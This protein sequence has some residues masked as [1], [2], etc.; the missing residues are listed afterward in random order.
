MKKITFLL[1]SLSLGLSVSAQVASY[2]EGDFSVGKDDV[3]T[4]TG[5][6]SKLYF[7]GI[8]AASSLDDVWLAKYQQSPDYT[9]L[10]INLGD[11]MIGDDRLLIGATS[12]VD[13]LFYS[14]IS[15]YNNG[16]VGINME[17]PEYNLHV[18]GSMKANSISSIDINCSG[19]ILAENLIAN[20]QIYTPN[21]IIATRIITDTLSAGIKL[22]GGSLDI[23]GTIKA[24]KLDLNGTIK[25]KEIV[26]TNTVWADFVFDKD[27][28]LPSLY[29]VE[30]HIQQHQTLPGI[31]SEEE[32]SEKGV[33]LAKM[34]VRLLQKVEELTLYVIQQQ[35][36]IDALKNKN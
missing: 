20:Q 22:E 30:E 9:D 4:A 7:K 31:P 24:T 35:K 6:G 25:A 10:V 32:V 13:N 33:D 8:N 29:E 27:Y 16:K 17:N 19:N 5:L 15:I 12:F 2:S 26:V 14:A 11:N 21:Q 36:E 18:N 34:N 3:T 23:R 28:R 1:A